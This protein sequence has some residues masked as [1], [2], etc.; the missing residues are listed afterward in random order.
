MVF[1]VTY[2]VNGLLKRG[3]VGQKQYEDFQKDSRI[4]NLQAYPNQTFMEKAFNESTG[5][6]NRQVLNG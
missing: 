6:P 2:Q 5:R 1:Y 4:S 3:I